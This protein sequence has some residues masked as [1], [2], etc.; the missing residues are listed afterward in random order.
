MVFWNIYVKS[1]D[2]KGGFRLPGMN[3]RDLKP[4][5]WIGKR[6]L[7]DGILREIKHQLESKKL[8]KIKVLKSIRSEFPQILEKIKQESGAD[9]IKK[10][11]FTIILRKV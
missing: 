5:I 3:V 7:T 8:I 4:T 10:I 1:V 2:P 11:G 9:E 6:G